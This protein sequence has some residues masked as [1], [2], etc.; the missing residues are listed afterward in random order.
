M[1]LRLIAL[2]AVAALALAGCGKRGTLERPPPLWGDKAK[3]DYQAQQAAKKDDTR[4]S[5]D[6][7]AST[8]FDPRHPDAPEA[9]HTSPR[10]DPLDG[11]TRGPDAGPNTPN[12]WLQQNQPHGR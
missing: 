1:S 12:Q 10:T 2:T 5:D 3:A 6:R 4:D 11:P 7:K 8:K 9:Q